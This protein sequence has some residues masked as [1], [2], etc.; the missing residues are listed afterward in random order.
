M[1]RVA[2]ATDE[3]RR[4]IALRPA[5]VFA[6]TAIVAAILYAFRLGVPS[7]AANEAY[8]AWAAAM[9]SARAIIAIPTLVDPGRELVHYIALHYFS[10]FSGLSEAGIRSLSVIFA[11][12]ALGLVYATAREMFDDGAGAAAA[13]IWAFNPLAYIYAH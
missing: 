6:L 9:P 8:S 11:L 13:A 2:T 12:A 5:A 3:A 10:I 4:E 7:L 1:A